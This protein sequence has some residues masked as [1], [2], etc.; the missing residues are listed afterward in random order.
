MLFPIRKGAAPGLG[1]PARPVDLLLACHARIRRFTCL[2]ADIIA[3]PDAPPADI[4]EA[5]RVLVRYHRFALPLHEADE[6][7]SIR[8]RLEACVI[9]D[10]LRGELV[11]ITEAH[12]CIDA[13]VEELITG[14]SAL[15]EAPKQLV[16]LALTLAPRTAALSHMWEPHLAREEAI[17]FPALARLSIEAE[18]AILAE[19]RARRAASLEG[20]PDASIPG[21]GA[22]LPSR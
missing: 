19:M 21:S 15:A 7:L 4:A 16:P 2:A 5:A 3:C 13:I 17:V 22:P 14:W 9:P 11:A 18:R 12:R 1:L 8:P 20:L 10:A 6:D